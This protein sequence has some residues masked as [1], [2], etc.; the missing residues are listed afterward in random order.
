MRRQSS[1]PGLLFIAYCTDPAL[2]CRAIFIASLRDAKCTNSRGGPLTRP[3]TMRL[4]A[5][6]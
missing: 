3:H 4:L 5:F 6:A 2:K 1:L